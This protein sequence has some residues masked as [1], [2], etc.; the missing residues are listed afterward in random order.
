MIYRLPKWRD[1][2]SLW[3]H[4]GR[5]FF[6]SHLSSPLILLITITTLLVVPLNTVEAQTPAGYS[7]YYI[8]GGTQQLWDIYVDLDND[9]VLD[10][11][12]GLHAVIAVTAT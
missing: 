8:P 5:R 3:K 7:E 9:P 12:Q 1:V 6:I 2:S 10:S 11:T 4:A